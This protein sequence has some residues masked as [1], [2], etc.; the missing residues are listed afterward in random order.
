[1]KKDWEEK[2][3]FSKILPNNQIITAC[4][5]GLR[6][7]KM[8]M[9]EKLTMIG[10]MFRSTLPE[11]LCEKDVLRNFAKFTGKHLCWGLFFNKLASLRPASLLTLWHRYFPIN[12][13]K[14]LNTFFSCFCMFLILPF[15]S[16][17][18]Q[19]R[20]HFHTKII[21]VYYRSKIKTLHGYFWIIIFPQNRCILTAPHSVVVVSY[22]LRI[23]KSYFL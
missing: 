7:Q 3:K 4:R 17:A 18:Y 10:L 1:M 20:K 11:L 21:W 6:V 9:N 13:A 22:G 23:S 5:I 15:L 16:K 2:T 8:T 12:F 14:F 19:A